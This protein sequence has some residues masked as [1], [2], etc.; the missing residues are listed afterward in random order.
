MA[1]YHKEST[2]FAP[3]YSVFQFFFFDFVSF[4][5]IFVFAL[6]CLFF[7]SFGLSCLIPLSVILLHFCITNSYTFK[8][9]GPVSL[10]LCC[11]HTVHTRLSIMPMIISICV[12]LAAGTHCVRD[13]CYLHSTI[14]KYYFQQ[15]LYEFCMP[16]PMPMHII[17]TQGRLNDKA[18][19]ALCVCSRVLVPV[20]AS[21]C[22]RIKFKF[23]CCI[24]FIW[25]LL[26]LI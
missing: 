25:I 12:G 15:H 7:Y 3:I 21:V 16:M 2:R 9:R 6:F 1:T 5:F 23:V 8:I 26:K 17:Y 11:V 24:Q 14:S 13:C 10:A 20:C 22:T 19:I 4:D 18:D